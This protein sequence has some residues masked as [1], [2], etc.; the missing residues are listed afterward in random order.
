MRKGTLGERMA[1]GLGW[2]DEGLVFTTPLHRSYSPTSV[3]NAF[4]A[5]CRRLGLPLIRLHDTRHTA[6]SLMLADG[7]PVTVVSAVLGH[8][9]PQIT[10]T[11]YAHMLPGNVTW[12]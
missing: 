6:A 9:S 11:T 2:D 4:R 3:S 12:R 5:A 7:V 1:L 10:M 8:S